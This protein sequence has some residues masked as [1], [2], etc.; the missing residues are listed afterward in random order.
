[1]FFLLFFSV[2]RGPCIVSKHTIHKRYCVLFE[3]HTLSFIS[4]FCQGCQLIFSGV[5]WRERLQDISRH[6]LSYMLWVCW[7]TVVVLL[8]IK[9]ISGYVCRLEL[10]EKT[11][12][13]PITDTATTQTH[14]R[15]YRQWLEHSSHLQW[16]W[17]ELSGCWEKGVLYHRTMAGYHFPDAV[18]TPLGSVLPL[19]PRSKS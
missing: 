15:D 13:P 16:Q 4:W 18:C 11:D 1:M 17:G 2:W 12:R 10:T 3:T 14:G 7:Q 5:L 9:L 19:K 8:S 6:L